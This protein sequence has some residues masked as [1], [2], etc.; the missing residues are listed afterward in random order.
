MPVEQSAAASGAAVAYASH[1]EQREVDRL[2]RGRRTRRNVDDGGSP[3]RGPASPM[4][5]I[6]PSVNT[7]NLALTSS[8]PA[9]SPKALPGVDATR[10]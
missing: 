5:A 10:R 1:D 4:T 8:M 9:P 6:A 7:Q 2:G 3:G